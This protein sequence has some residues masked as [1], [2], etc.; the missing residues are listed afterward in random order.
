MLTSGDTAAA[1]RRL[2]RLRR[3][4]D[5]RR[6]DPHGQHCAT[7]SRWA[8]SCSGSTRDHQRQGYGAR[9]LAHAEEHART[10]GR[11][12]LRAQARIGEGLEPATAPSPSGTGYTLAMTEI[13]RRL[14]AAGRPRR[15]STGW[16]PRPRRTTATTRSAPFVGPV[17]GRAARVVRRR[18]TTCSA[19]R[20]RTAT[21]S[22]RPGGTPSR[23]STPLNASATQAGRTAR[24]GRRAARRRR[25]RATPTHPCPAATT[26]TSTSTARSSTP[27]IAATGSGWP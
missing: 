16:R 8:R 3:R 2:R 23:T 6:D 14:A 13:E 19:S 18:S 10:R 22:S 17:P 25:G 1:L 9:L 4:P 20:C 27:T 26:T 7:T 24:R 15:C 21:S 11:R 12:I 5:G